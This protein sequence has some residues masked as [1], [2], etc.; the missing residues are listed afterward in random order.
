MT[1][2]KMDQLTLWLE[3]VKFQL[4]NNIYKEKENR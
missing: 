3:T 2:A 4:Y 1:L